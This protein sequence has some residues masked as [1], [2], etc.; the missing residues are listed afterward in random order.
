MLD[1]ELSDDYFWAI[2]D[3]LRLLKLRKG[4]LVSAELGKG[5]KGA[6]Y[7]LRKSKDETRSWITRWLALKPAAYTLYLQPRDESGANALGELRERGNQLCR[8][9]SRPVQ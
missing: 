5:N 1:K 7:T 2:E 4:V 9:C 8:Q 3:H 6:N